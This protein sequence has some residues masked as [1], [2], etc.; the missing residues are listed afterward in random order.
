MKEHNRT[1]HLSCIVC[2]FDDEL[3]DVIL[4]FADLIFYFRLFLSKGADVDAVGVID[5]NPLM[6]AASCS[7]AKVVESLVGGGRGEP[8][9]P[10][11]LI[12]NIE[13]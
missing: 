10:C 6:R 9:M 3:F 11:W 13:P 12:K 2:M 8:V 7:H 4:K 1:K 5:D